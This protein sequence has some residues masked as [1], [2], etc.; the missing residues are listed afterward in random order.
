MNTDEQEEKLYSCELYCKQLFAR[1][2]IGT[3]DNNTEL[4][5]ECH[6]CVQDHTELRSQKNI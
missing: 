2:I 1:A 5:L 4:F 6:V 3:K